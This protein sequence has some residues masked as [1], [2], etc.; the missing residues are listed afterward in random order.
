MRRGGVLTQQGRQFSVFEREG[1]IGVE[2][3]GYARCRGEDIVQCRPRLFG[4]RERVSRFG[5][6]RIRG[7]ERV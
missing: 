5:W 2:G 6:K 1:E 3:F 4:V 7:R